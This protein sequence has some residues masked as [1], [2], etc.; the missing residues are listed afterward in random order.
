MDD[1]QLKRAWKE[2][3]DQVYKEVNDQVY[4]EI[5]DEWDRELEQDLQRQKDVEK[6]LELKKI[7]QQ[8]TIEEFFQ[9]MVDNIDL[10]RLLYDYLKDL[11][12]EYNYGLIIPTIDN[13]ITLKDMPDEIKNKI[14][15][16]AHMWNKHYFRRGEINE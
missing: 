14:E 5:F 2:V 1:E 9:D 6:S 13:K 8:K 11:Y 16:Y 7:E 12:V 3:N 15:V 10:E 4:K